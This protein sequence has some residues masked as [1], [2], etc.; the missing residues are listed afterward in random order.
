MVSKA[1][2]HLGNALTVLEMVAPGWSRWHSIAA[3]ILRN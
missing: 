2:F 3:I 1:D